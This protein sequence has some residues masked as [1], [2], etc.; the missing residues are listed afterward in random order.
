MAK[1]L[2][3]SGF[4]AGELTTWA[5]TGIP[6]IGVAVILEYYAFDAGRY[7][8]EQARR[9]YKAF[10]AIGI[11]TW[12]QQVKGWQKEADSSA[13]QPSTPSPTPEEIASFLDLS[14]AKLT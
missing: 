11:R 8:K 6:D 1:K 10:A 13:P 12:M 5:S 14:L 4:V 9:V 2:V 7:C 3:E